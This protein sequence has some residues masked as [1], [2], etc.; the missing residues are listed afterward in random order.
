M[1][2]YNNAHKDATHNEEGLGW[3]G[4]AQAAAGQ[5]ATEKRV[6]MLEAHQ[7]EIHAS[8][9]SMEGEAARLYQACSSVSCGSGAL[10]FCSSFVLHSSGHK[11]HFSGVLG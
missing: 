8:L 2:V 6:R 9:A 4:C 7:A 3:R 11:L 5:D 10:R 1:K